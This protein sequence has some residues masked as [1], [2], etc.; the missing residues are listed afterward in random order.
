MRRLWLKMVV[1]VVIITI[2]VTKDSGSNGTQWWHRT[3]L[4]LYGMIGTSARYGFS[5]TGSNWNCGGSI[6]NIGSGYCG[7]NIT[8]DAN[9]LYG[10]PPS[11]PLSSDQ[12]SI[13]SWE[14]I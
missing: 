9:L 1:L 10:P 14:E 3:T 13:I 12:Y 6:G 2:Q 5:F 4:N 7:R 11:F 8:Y